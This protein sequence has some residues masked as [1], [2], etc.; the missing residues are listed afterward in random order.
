MPYFVNEFDLLHTHRYFINYSEGTITRELVD[1]SNCL[2]SGD[3]ICDTLADPG[4]SSY[5]KELLGKRE[6]MNSWHQGCDYDKETCEIIEC[7]TDANG[8]VYEPDITNFMSYY[9]HCI[10]SFTP[11]QRQVMICGLSKENYWEV[12]FKK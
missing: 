7:G 10:N 1:G 9:T 8:D 3:Y 5:W 12:F 4:L 6:W 2:T 11:T